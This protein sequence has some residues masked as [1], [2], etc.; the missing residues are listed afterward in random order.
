ML[1]DAC[2][3]V[4]ASVLDAG[5]TALH[6]LRTSLDSISLDAAEAVLAASLIGRV[7]PVLTALL[8]TL[9]STIGVQ[10]PLMAPLVRVLR[11]FSPV[12]AA[13]EA[14]TAA[15]AEYNAGRAY[16]QSGGAVRVV[17]SA[18]P[19]TANT[20]EDFSV[21]IPG[22]HALEITFSSQ[23]N[24][25]Y[26]DMLTLYL[27]RGH[28]S[29]FRR[30]ESYGA[31][32][33]TRVIVPGDAVYFHFKSQSQS[34]G[35]YGFKATVTPQLKAEAP[36]ELPW[37]LDTF[38]SLGY[39]AG[40]YAAMLVAAKPQMEVPPS[41]A[42]WRASPLLSGGLS[43]IMLRANP[44]AA[45]GDARYDLAPLRAVLEASTAQL[46]AI[47]PAFAETPQAETDVF[48]S[49]LDAFVAQGELPLEA[50]ATPDALPAKLNAWI[51]NN[52]SVQV[53]LARE[54]PAAAWAPHACGT[55]SHVGDSAADRRPQTLVDLVLR[56][57][58][59]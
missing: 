42:H 52:S 31:F 58:S 1:V 46:P 17:E 29:R 51:L 10:A 21:R 24:L 7:F 8:G 15:E 43:S 33:E 27:K 30:F 19:Y 48:T 22:A 4:V 50:N 14:N 6:K 53:F 16:R 18:H 41:L 35:D 13:F 26:N 49:F 9:G 2:V 32:Q 34:Y 37:M 20:D 56:G 57:P 47:P 55:S 45:R 25:Q 12:A 40:K 11:E 54:P 36:L 44:D 38:K 39:V 28:K 3:G 23:S 59:W 5:T